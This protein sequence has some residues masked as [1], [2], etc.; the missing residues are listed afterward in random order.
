MNC[1]IIFLASL[2]AEMLALPFCFSSSGLMLSIIIFLLC[3]FIGYETETLLTTCAYYSKKYSYMSLSR[4]MIKS[5]DKNNNA[6][7]IFPFAVKV[8]FFL[9]N[10]GFAVT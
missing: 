6:S 7:K 5:L 8:T 2:T 3:T 1:L 10:L 9:T 4:E